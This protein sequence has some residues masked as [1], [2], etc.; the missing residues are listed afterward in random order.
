MTLVQNN[1]LMFLVKVNTVRGQGWFKLLIF[2]S[3]SLSSYIKVFSPFWLFKGSTSLPQTTSHNPDLNPVFL[4]IHSAPGW[5]FSSVFKVKSLSNH[6]LDCSRSRTCSAFFFS[7]LS[8]SQEVLL[9]APG[10][11]PLRA[12]ETEALCLHLRSQRTFLSS[13]TPHSPLWPSNLVKLV[14]IVTLA[15]IWEKKETVFI[16]KR[17]KKEREGKGG[18]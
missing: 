10:P 6:R 9:S 17:G 12:G 11:F 7:H 5:F 2:G 13:T 18:R 15:M 16:R 4:H 3:T 8:P 14:K 1:Q